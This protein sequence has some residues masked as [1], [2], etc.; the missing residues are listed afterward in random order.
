DGSGTPVELVGSWADVSER[1][2]AERAAQ[3]AQEQLAR[4]LTLSPIVLYSLQIDAGRVVSVWNSSNVSQV[5]G[6]PREQTLTIDWW[7]EHVHPEDVADLRLPSM[8]DHE[9]VLREFR[10]RYADGRWLGS[11]MKR[12]CCAMLRGAPPRSS[13]LGPISPPTRRRNKPPS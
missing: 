5:T 13:A 12:G 1:K 6:Y 11:A 9:H 10:F 2:R 4:V 8:L 7:L 3:Q